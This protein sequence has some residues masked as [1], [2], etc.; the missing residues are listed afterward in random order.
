MGEF[1]LP[2]KNFALKREGEIVMHEVLS[3]PD[4]SSIGYIHEVD[5]HYPEQLH[6]FHSNF[7]LAPTKEKTCFFSGSGNNRR[8]RW[9]LREQKD[10]PQKRTN[11]FKRLTREP[12]T[13][14]VTL[15]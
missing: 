5:L 1:P 15:L 14:F 7:P 8:R 2:S 6:N 10:S 4:D 3:T 12:I 11:C 9:N 13:H